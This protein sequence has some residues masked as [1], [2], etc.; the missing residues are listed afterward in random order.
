MMTTCSA[1][2]CRWCA[3]PR[4]GG[5]ACRPGSDRP[6]G[7]DLQEVATGNAVAEALFGSQSVSMRI[8]LDTWAKPWANKL[9]VVGI[10]WASNLFREKSR[11]TVGGNA[12]E[13]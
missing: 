4:S 3:P 5:G 10:V 12:V 13:S 11:D 7:A 8:P 1:S 2:A 9:M 6:E